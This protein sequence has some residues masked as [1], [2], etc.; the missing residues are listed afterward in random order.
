MVALG[1]AVMVV[2]TLPWEWARRR[3]RRRVLEKAV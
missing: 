2:M 3:S 1:I